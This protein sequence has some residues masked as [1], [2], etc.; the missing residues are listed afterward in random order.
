VRWTAM[1]IALR[2]FGLV[3]WLVG[4]AACGGSTA[5][6][7]A[8]PSTSTPGSTVSPAAR[9]MIIT[10]G[11]TH[12][13]SAYSGLGSLPAYDNL[14]LM[15]NFVIR[16]A[17]DRAASGH[18]RV[19]YTN[20]SNLYT[21]PSPQNQAWYQPFLAM[22]AQVGTVEF[23]RASQAPLTSFDVVIADFCSVPDDAERAILAAHVM[24]GGRA[25]VLGDNF[26]WSSAINR[27]SAASA[28]L[29]LRD[30]GIAFTTEET[31]SREPLVIA[32]GDQRDL[33][34]GVSLLNVFRVTPQSVSGPWTPIVTDGGKI[35]AAVATILPDGGVVR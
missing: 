16:L 2:R 20:K 4:V 35:L 13:Y 24:A 32:S 23:R 31:P 25:L 7:P 33:L 6:A 27:T 19:L 34:A 29:L 11:F 10:W 22:M 28:N 26:C 8:S 21:D 1:A 12:I 9:G 17:E 5:S 30:F 18:I 14:A 15:R 3:V